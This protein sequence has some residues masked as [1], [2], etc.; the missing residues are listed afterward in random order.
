MSVTR[1]TRKLRQLK[2]D[3]QYPLAD[4]NPAQSLSGLAPKPLS[5]R[6]AAWLVLEDV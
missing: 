6:R 4:L 1:Y 5:A 2:R 3:E